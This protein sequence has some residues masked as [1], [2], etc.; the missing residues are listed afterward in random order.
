[1]CWLPDSV[2]F[3]D[4]LYLLRLISICIYFWRTEHRKL[5][6]QGTC[7]HDHHPDN[8]LLKKTISHGHHC[9][10]R[11]VSSGNNETMLAKDEEIATLQSQLEKA[12]KEVEQ[13]KAALAAVKK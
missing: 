5:M 3:L 9:L 11:S 13:V 12:Q 10:V 2:Y 8:R 7:G 1:M 4:W 6:E